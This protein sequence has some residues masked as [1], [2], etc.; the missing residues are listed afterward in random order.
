MHRKEY[1][2][3]RNKEEREVNPSQELIKVKGK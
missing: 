1:Q 2:I 3:R